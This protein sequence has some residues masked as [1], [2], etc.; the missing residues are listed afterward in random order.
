MI[1][2]LHNWF[3]RIF[4]A[5]YLIQR[6]RQL[7]AD[8]RLEIIDLAEENVKAN[9]ALYKV[10]GKLAAARGVPVE[11]VKKENDKEVFNLAATRYAKSYY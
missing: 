9:L 1:V 6:Q 7:I 8:M 4:R 3:E 5:R 2:I 10:M 11:E